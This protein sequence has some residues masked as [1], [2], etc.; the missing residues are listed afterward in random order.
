MSF[1]QTLKDTL[2]S[3]LGQAVIAEVPDV[4]HA[5]AE[6]AA[7]PH[8][9]LQTIAELCATSF[10]DIHARLEKVESATPVAPLELAAPA[11]ATID[12]QAIEQ[13]VMTILETINPQLAKFEPLLDL[14][15]Q[16]FPH[17]QTAQSKPAA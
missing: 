7:N 2:Q 10:A 1:L 5:G 8:M 17:L 16:H 14:I 13:I 4:I 11:P 15:A 3:R 6:I 12:A 9:A